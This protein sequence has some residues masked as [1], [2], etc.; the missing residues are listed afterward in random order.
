MM[1]AP[2]GPTAPPEGET[3][4][5]AAEAVTPALA[6]ESHSSED[7]GAPDAVPP[8]DTDPDGSQ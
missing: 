5:P 4:A 1:P 7:T 2:S 6:A 8:H 3:H